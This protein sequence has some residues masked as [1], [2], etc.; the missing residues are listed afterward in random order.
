M[1]MAP[2]LL[3]LLLSRLCTNTPRRTGAGVIIGSMAAG[4]K[5]REKREGLEYRRADSY[6][7]LVGA[8]RCVACQLQAIP[9][10]ESI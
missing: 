5:K 4:A 2:L 10:G 1:S 9:M 6:E 7:S 8:R 3:L